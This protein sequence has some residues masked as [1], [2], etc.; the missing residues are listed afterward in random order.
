MANFGK[1]IL[2]FLE[3][4]RGATALEYGLIAALM[5]VAAIASFTAFGNGL[6]NVFGSTTEGAGGA[7]T[8]AASSL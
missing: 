1:T 4:E 7:I 5:A 2:N 6:Q 3:D 8:D